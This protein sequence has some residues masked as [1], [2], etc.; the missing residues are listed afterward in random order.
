MTYLIGLTGRARA[1]KDTVARM[2]GIPRYSFADKLREFLYAMNPVVLSDHGETRTLAS[3]VDEYGWEGIKGTPYA[4]DVR[5][6]MQ[7][8]GV[9]SRGMYGEDVWVNLLDEKVYADRPPIAVISDVRF[10]N[11]A[12]WVRQWGNGEVWRIERPGVEEI[13]RAHV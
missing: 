6:I 12:Q 7:N 8:Y 4:F 10:D 3:A 5:R 11:E 9:A 2:L 1:G 13:G